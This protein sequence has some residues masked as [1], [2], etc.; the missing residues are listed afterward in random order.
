VEVTPPIL[1]LGTSD[2]Q[3]IQAVL[4]SLRR[5]G[6]V[7]RRVQAIRPNLEELFFA[8]VGQAPPPIPPMSGGY[9]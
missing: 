3:A 6:C 7:I 5:S 9:T 1:R 8:A 2:P 4:D